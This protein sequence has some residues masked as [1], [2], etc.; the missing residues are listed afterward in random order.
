MSVLLQFK[1]LPISTG[2]KCDLAIFLNMMNT[3]LEMKLS[4]RNAYGF[5]LMDDSVLI[6]AWCRCS[7]FCQGK[8]KKGDLYTYFEMIF[9]STARYQMIL[10]SRPTSKNI[11]FALA[12]CCRKKPNKLWSPALTLTNVGESLGHISNT[13]ILTVQTEGRPFMNKNK[14]WCCELP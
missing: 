11:L 6:H 2:K 14:A 9:L 5:L 3:T 4:K 10:I 7:Y 1:I 12:S 13:L 8:R